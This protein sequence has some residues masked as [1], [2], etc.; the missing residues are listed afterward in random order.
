MNRY[1]ILLYRRFFIDFNELYLK[2]RSINAALQKKKIK[3]ELKIFFEF[4]LNFKVKKSLKKILIQTTF[5]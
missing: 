5:S 2:R 3:T 4:S 1:T